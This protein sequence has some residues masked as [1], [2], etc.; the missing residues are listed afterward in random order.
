MLGGTPTATGGTAPYTYAW[1]P[2]TNISSTTTSN[3]IANP[4]QPTWYF[5][6]VTDDSGYTARDSVFIDLDPLYAYNAGNDVSICTGDSVTL[7]SPNNSF[8]G[9]VMYQWSPATGLDD[10]NAPRPVSSTTVTITYSVIIT[11]PNCPSKSYDVKV[12]VNPL[13]VVDA[14][15]PATINEGDAVVVTATGGV[16]YAW[17]PGNTVSDPTAGT[18]TAEPTQTTTYLVYGIDANNCFSWDT[19]TITVVPSS[20]LVFYNTF[21]P[22][23]DGVNDYF[24]IG[25]VG[26]YPECRLEV[27]TRTG[28]LVYAKTAYDNSWDGTN[29]GDRLPE[30]TYYYTF[31]PGDGS[32][33]VFGHVT[34][35]R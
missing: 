15:C 8:A 32:A 22:N 19:L 13:P 21:S 28:Q 30:A 29:Y 33:A 35:V 24:F 9:G 14:C 6:T 2:N 5:L 11:S 7:G 17:V 20:E 34:I 27:Y 23:N 4:T 3:P 1:T 18:T 10:D 12:T 31:N 26:K 25:N 16:V